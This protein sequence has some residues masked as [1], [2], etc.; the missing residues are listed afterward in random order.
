MFDTEVLV[1]GGG[2][3]GS[4]TALQLARS[5]HRV[6]L[7][8]RA[9]FPRDKVCG[10]GLMPYGVGEL[11]RLG[12]AAPEG[13]Q[14]FVGIGYTVGG[15]SAVGRFPGGRYGL[16]VRRSRLDA[17]LAARC[18]EAGVERRHGVQVRGAGGWSGR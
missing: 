17:E 18:E 13:S 11:E 1:I 14:R 12:L 8:D 6:M 10:E 4:A 9:G 16:G 15:H 7:L 3:G 5:G 2:P